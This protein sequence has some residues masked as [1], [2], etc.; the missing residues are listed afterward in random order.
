MCGGDNI[1]VLH[2]FKNP[3]YLL[4]DLARQRVEKI[5][6]RAFIFAGSIED[7]GSL[8][9]LMLTCTLTFVNIFKRLG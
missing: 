9:N 4:G 6:N 8:H 7:N 5:L 2:Q 3:G 1:Q